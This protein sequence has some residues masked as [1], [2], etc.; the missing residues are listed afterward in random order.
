MVQ[1]I[2]DTKATGSY[3]QAGSPTI[4]PAGL[5]S[6][7]DLYDAA[8]MRQGVTDIRGDV[9]SLRTLGTELSSYKTTPVTGPI[10]DPNIETTVAPIDGTQENID[11]SQVSAPVDA[12]TTK[13]VAPPQRSLFE[14]LMFDQEAARELGATRIEQLTESILQREK[15]DNVNLTGGMEAA[16]IEIEN[17][18]VLLESQG[19]NNAAIEKTIGRITDD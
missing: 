4:D 10:T 7:I 1:G 13:T 5:R 11:D 3:A 15:I 12:T 6:G 8:S 2:R 16:K 17:Y 14:Q 19:V 9:D 18:R